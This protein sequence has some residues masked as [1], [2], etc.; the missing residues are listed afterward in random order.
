MSSRPV[1][2]W[3]GAFG[4]DYIQRNQAGDGAVRQRT[5]IWGRYLWPIMS[6]LPTSVLE[7]GCNVGIN[8]RALDRLI[9]ADLYA[10]EPNAAARNVVLSEGVLPSERLF[11]ADASKIPMGDGAVDLSFT[12]GV[13]IHV[14]PAELASAVDELY[15]VSR[16]YILISEY[17]ADQPEEKVY[18]GQD[19][20]LFKR[21]FGKFLLERHPDLTIVDYGFLWKEA[22]ASDNGNWWLF[23]KP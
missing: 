7:V 1:D 12:T 22:G 14:P 18:R 3:R 23:K 8:L 16:R 19:G 5:L 13:L 20:L 10:V 9:D 2:H 11:D 21:D 15:R 17:F 6:A 4:A